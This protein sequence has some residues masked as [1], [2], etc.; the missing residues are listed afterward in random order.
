[1]YCRQT[2]IAKFRKQNGDYFTLELTTFSCQKLKKH[3]FTKCKEEDN[4]DNFK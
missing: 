4:A 2:Q 3:E 1:M